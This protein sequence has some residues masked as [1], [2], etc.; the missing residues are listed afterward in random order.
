MQ[1]NKDNEVEYVAYC[2]IH[3]RRSS[4]HQGEDDYGSMFRCPSS[5]EHLSHLFHVRPD[6]TA[7]KTAEEIA[8]WRQAQ[9]EKKAVAV[10]RGQLQ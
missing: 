9:L 7:P 3:G 10:G 5:P 8:T 6:P 4:N 2:P 1:L